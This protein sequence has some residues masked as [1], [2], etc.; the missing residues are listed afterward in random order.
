MHIRALL[1]SLKWLPAAD[2]LQTGT[3]SKTWNSVA[4]NEELWSCLLF[5]KSEDL[6]LS[7]T[8]SIFP[9]SKALY[10][11]LYTY[12][13][14]AVVFHSKYA[15]FDLKTKSTNYIEL[16][17]TTT[18]TRASYLLFLPDTSL[19]ACGGD[20]RST[21]YY[22]SG[23]T[24]AY[25]I[26]PIQW[27][28]AVLSEMT[29]QRRFP[30]AYY[31]K[32]NVY[33][34][35]GANGSIDLSS[36]ELLSVSRNEWRN[37]PNAGERRNSFTPVMHNLEIFLVGGSK[38]NTVEA[39]H[40]QKLAYRKLPILLPGK[41]DCT[42]VVL[43]SV[44]TAFTMQRAFEFNLGTEAQQKVTPILSHDYVWSNGQPLVYKGLAWF[45]YWH[46][47]TVIS[48]DF[49]GRFVKHPTFTFTSLESRN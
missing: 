39:F 49:N 1:E 21:S 42:S 35:G 23:L 12:H 14:I 19:F 34:F 28:V 20:V 18:I 26:A 37:L 11:A 15:Q 47:E 30:G 44:L 22:D 4:E 24:S 6:L 17:I 43:D 8:L 10:Q 29:Q 38:T 25:R 9:T 41:V 3:V 16:L 32:G 33:V 48:Y 27:T 45:Y 13:H 5:D 31:Y 36:A 2:I 46:L 7:T 40:V